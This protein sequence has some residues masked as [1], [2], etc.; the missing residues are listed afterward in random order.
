MTQV[1][2]NNKVLASTEMI[3]FP[4]KKDLAVPFSTIPDENVVLEGVNLMTR[5]KLAVAS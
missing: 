2:T 5:S 3:D 1:I 4:T